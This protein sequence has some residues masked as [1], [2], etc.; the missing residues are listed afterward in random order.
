MGRTPTAPPPGDRGPDDDDDDAG[1]GGGSDDG[2]GSR[3]RRPRR[4]RRGRPRPREGRRRRRRVASAALD[5]GASADPGWPRA[6]AG[7]P[8]RRCREP[9]REG[10]PPVRCRR[11]AHRGLRPLPAVQRRPRPVDRCP[12][13]RQR[14]LRRGLLDAADRRRSGSVSAGVHRGPRRPAREPVAGRP[15]G[16]TA[17]GGARELP[18]PVVRSDQRGGAGGGRPTR[19]YAVGV[20][21]GLRAPGRRTRIAGG[22]L[23]G[24]RHAGPDAVCR[25]V[26]RRH[27]DLPRAAHRR[28]RVR[29]LGDRPA[30][31]P[32]RPV[33]ARRRRSPT[34]SSIGTSASSCS[35]CRSCA[36]SRGCSTASSSRRLL[37]VARPLPR[38]RVARRARLLDAGA[39]PPR[40]PRRRSSCCRSRSATSSTSSSSS[41]STRGVATGVSFTDQNAQFFAYDVLTVISGIA[42][43][44]LVGGAFTR[45]LWPLGLTIAVWFLASLVIG[46]LYPEAIQRFTVAPEPVRPGRALHRQQHRDD[47]AGLRPRRL[48]GPAVQRATAVL[49]RRTG[50]RS[51][52][53]TFAQRSAVGLRARCRTT[54]DQLQ[55]V[56]KYYDFTDVDT[57]RYAIDGSQRQVMLSGRELA[58]EQN[59]RATGWVNQRIIYTHGIGVAM[60][61]V[62]EVG[63]EGQPHLLIGNLPPVSVRRRAD[64]SPSRASTS[65]SGRRSYVVVGAKQDEFDYPTGDSDT[66]GSV[67]TADAL[68]RDDRDQARQDADAAPVRGPLPGP[69]PAHQRPG[70]GRAASSC[71]IAR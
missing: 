22:R 32:P 21:R 6:R 46:R 57:D 16:T 15:A 19:R 9:C 35:S 48:G 70:H 60:V 59:P 10:G 2:E 58:L 43:A 38:R 14:R 47:A 65:A 34:R 18:A 44:L 54:L 8:E 56:R 11:A 3:A 62:N 61:P 17:G 53:D 30:L 26:P 49:T 50:R 7:R 37:L 42:A 12:V 69:R 51:E 45:M 41:Y 24:R 63:S 1:D 55:T 27:R 36:S 68:D 71:S 33:L 23:R 31:G 52:A 4:R 29:C 13:V 5:R 66:G 28:L 20:R 40:R 39:R 67:G 25:L 64:R